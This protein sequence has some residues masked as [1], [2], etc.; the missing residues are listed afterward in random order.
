MVKILGKSETLCHRWRPGSV[1]PWAMIIF[2]K[3][4][5][6]FLLSFS[7]CKFQS[8]TRCLGIIDCLFV[9]A[10]KS[11]K[12]CTFLC[13]FECLCAGLWL[14]V[15]V[16]EYLWICSSR[17]ESEWCLHVSFSVEYVDEKVTRGTG[18]PVPIELHTYLFF[19]NACEF[20]SPLMNTRVYHFF[21]LLTL[22][23]LIRHLWPL[24]FTIFFQHSMVY[25]FH[26]YELPVILQQAQLQQLLLRNH[27]V[28]AAHS[29]TP[30]TAPSTPG[31][32]PTPTPSG[33]PSPSTPTTEQTQQNYISELTQLDADPD[34]PGGSDTVPSETSSPPSAPLEGSIIHFFSYYFILQYIYSLIYLLFSIIVTL[35]CFIYY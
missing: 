17:W 21:C 27:P 32:S 18:V 20:N 19:F 29:P 34:N 23:N 31:P 25:F 7:Q 8:I 6:V 15:S 4:L 14:P 22:V 33:S 28:P 9:R 13:M 5:V 10:S 1:L 24:V 35:F 16:R 30:S 26:H 3:W 12:V 2:L 11:L